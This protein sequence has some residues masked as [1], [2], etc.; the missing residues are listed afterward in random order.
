MKLKSSVYLIIFI[1]ANKNNN[2]ELH[3]ELSARA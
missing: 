2:S 3:L 1:V